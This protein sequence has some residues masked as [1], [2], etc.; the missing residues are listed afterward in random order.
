MRKP[1]C[2]LLLPFLL[3]LF[4]ATEAVAQAG[5]VTGG[6]RPGLAVSD[7][8]GV[9]ASVV[10]TI[11][12]LALVVAVI[13]AVGFVLRR[14]NPGLKNSVTLLRP[15]A[16]LSLGPKER[17]A[18]IQFQ[19]ELL[20][21][22]VTANQISLLTKSAASNLDPQRDGQPPSSEAL[23]AKWLGR[24]KGTSGVNRSSS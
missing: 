8:P 23:V 6:A 1:I 17:L 7:A 14:V 3:L 21:L 12:A 24:I 4:P 9:G 2:V 19:G 22:G 10:P 15:V 20:V 5:A 18:V 11:A 13:L 16:Y